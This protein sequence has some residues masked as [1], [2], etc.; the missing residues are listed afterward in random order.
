M[1]KILLSISIILLV[2]QNILAQEIH[3]A[4]VVGANATFANL[5]KVMKDYYKSIEL[6]YC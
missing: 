4:P 1:R 2:N 5:S 6:G 3:V